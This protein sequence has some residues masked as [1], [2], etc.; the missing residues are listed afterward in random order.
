MKRKVLKDIGAAK[1]RVAETRAAYIRAVRAY[2]NWL[3]KERLQ[4][5]RYLEIIKENNGKKTQLKLNRKG[6]K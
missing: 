6:R 1:A 4:I 3:K 2:E 5:P